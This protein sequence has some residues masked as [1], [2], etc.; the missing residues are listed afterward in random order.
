MVGIE[1]T[2]T[3]RLLDALD[4]LG[5]TFKDFRPVFIEASREFY[6]IE[7]EQF[8][9]EGRSGTSG[10]WNPLTRAYAKWK[11]VAAP[12]KPILELTGTLRRS[13]TRPNARYSTRRITEEELLIGTTDPKAVF[14]FRGTKKM[15]ARPPVSLTAEQ[16]RRIIKVVRDGL[17]GEIKRGGKFL[18]VEVG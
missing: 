16:N 12:G 1:L 15:P 9:S 4:E 6:Q 5:A 11:Q 2:G 3:D 17:I 10:K 8:A 13:L 14:H 18:I 7:R